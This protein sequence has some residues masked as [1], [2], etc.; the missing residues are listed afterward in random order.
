MVVLYTPDYSLESPEASWKDSYTS[1]NVSYMFWSH[2]NFW[3]GC[4]MLFLYSFTCTILKSLTTILLTI[5]KQILTF[6][7]HTS[8]FIFSFI[9]L[10]M[11]VFGKET[12]FSHIHRK[13]IL[14]SEYPFCAGPTSIKV[15]GLVSGSWNRNSKMRD[16]VDFVEILHLFQSSYSFINFK[17]PS[18]LIS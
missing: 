16:K 7:S 14:L 3:M 9:F 13:N 6:P 12:Q 1:P 4:C 11:F 17:I 18:R 15:F 10:S 8:F 5:K 2:S